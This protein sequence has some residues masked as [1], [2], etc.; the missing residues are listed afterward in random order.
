MTMPL[1]HVRQLLAKT[2]VSR[3]AP[4]RRWQD[5]LHRHPLLALTQAGLAALPGFLLLLALPVGL[6]LLLTT[7]PAE[8]RQ[9]AEWLAPGI[10]L[11]LV[12]IGS[13]MLFGLVRPPLRKPRGLSLEHAMAPGLYEWINEAENQWGKPV[14]DRIVL[15]SGWGLRIVATPRFGLPWPAVRT[16]EIG[17]PMLLA[18]APEQFRALLSREIG[19]ATHQHA[20]LSGRLCRLGDLWDQYADHFRRH[21]NPAGRLFGFYA[22]WYRS[23]A[24]AACW[25]DTLA[26]DTGAIQMVND[27]ELAEVLA[28]EA[29][30]RQFLKLRFWPKVKELARREAT[31]KHLPYSSMGRVVARG[32]DREFVQQ[33]L[34]TVLQEPATDEAQPGL[35]QRLDHLGFRKPLPPRP[36][37]KFAAA[38]AIAP[39]SL[40]GILREFDQRWLKRQRREQSEKSAWN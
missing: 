40:V 17:L 7:W 15:R 21:G 9:P 34:Q 31:P 1:E 26:A 28:Q 11:L 13:I 37:K 29:V 6:L 4:R 10:G 20:L 30:T 22:P 36:L 12:V 32:M 24:A 16:L 39:A 3:W 8:I 27:R 5:F 2:P 35:S 19:R 23:R 33:A 14:V 25:L 38:E 18:L